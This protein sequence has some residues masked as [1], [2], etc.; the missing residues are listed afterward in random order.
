MDTIEKSA[1]E[2]EVTLVLSKPV[3][4]FAEFYASLGGTA[5]DALLT[6]ILLERLSEIKAQVKALPYL[7]ISELY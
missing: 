3:L 1:I 6:K 7:E 4:E 5:R 2:E